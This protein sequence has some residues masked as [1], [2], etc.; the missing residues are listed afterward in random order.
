[1]SQVNFRKIA[2]GCVALPALAAAGPTGTLY[3][4]GN[5]GAYLAILQGGRERDVATAFGDEG[6]IAV[7]DDVRTTGIQGGGYGASYSL[8][9]EFTGN[10]YADGV[11]GGARDATTDGTLNYL[12][13]GA[14][15]VETTDRSFGAASRLFNTG[16]LDGG[17]AYDPSRGTLWVAGEGFIT[18]YSLTG[19]PLSSIGISAS[20]P[21]ALAFDPSDGTLWTG[22]AFAGDTLLTQ[23][24]TSGGVLQ[25]Y[26]LGSGLDVVGMEFDEALS[27]VPE[28]ASLF[29][30][31][32]GV[33]PL[34]ARRRRSRPSANP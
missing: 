30:L 26:A 21:V 9:G 14:G 25:S 10:A 22:T 24:S 32:L 27:P 3:L 17:I 13:D 6:P 18:Q 5:G 15:N 12:L 4:T 1:M 33:A 11:S 20:G 28:P 29:A 19:Q 8:A 34:L 7:Y 2:L 23:Y 31:G 16:V